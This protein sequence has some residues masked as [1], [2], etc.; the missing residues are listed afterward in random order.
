MADDFFG[1]SGGEHHAAKKS[2]FLSQKVGGIPVWGIGAGLGSLL[3]LILL[4]RRRKSAASAAPSPVSTSLATTNPNLAFD[5]PNQTDP[6]TGSTYAQ[7]GYTTTSAVDSY[8]AGA[9]SG[10]HS[11]TGISPN[12]TQTTSGL[13]AP[14][15]NQQWGSLAA[16][17]L[18]A[19]GND[20]TLATN[21]VNDFLQGNPLSVA[22]QAVINLA[23]KMFGEPPEGVTAITPAPSGGAAPDPGTTGSGSPATTVPSVTGWRVSDAIPV[24][25]NAGFTIGTVSLQGIAGVRQS[26]ILSPSEYSQHIVT[27]TSVSGQTVS[28]EAS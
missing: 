21:A 18:I 27:G 5:D 25:T 9:T 6:A 28:I 8:L 14:V 10:A 11:P 22:E 15:T 12:G 2:G 23:L 26:R 16:D 20:P 4:L 13:P 24:I 19:Q 17:W 7:E 3:V 1:E